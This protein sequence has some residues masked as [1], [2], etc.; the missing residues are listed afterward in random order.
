MDP[1]DDG[2]EQ[3]LRRVLTAQ[4]WALAPTP[5][6]VDDV[7]AGVRRRRRNRAVALSTAGVIVIAGGVAAGVSLISGN[8]GRDTIKTPATQPPA[9][10]HHGPFVPWRATPGRLTVN[11]DTAQSDAYT[12]RTTETTAPACTM[13]DLGTALPPDG[14]AGSVYGTLYVRNTSVTPCSVQGVPDV[15]LLDAHGQVV[16]STATA[17]TQQQQAP[18]VVLD[19]GS[20][21]QAVIGKLAND[22]CGGQAS[23]QVRVSVS[24]EVGSTTFAEAFGGPVT[25]NCGNYTDPGNTPGNLHPQ[26]FTAIPGHQVTDNNIHLS[27]QSPQQVSPNTEV[28]YYVTVGGPPGSRPFAGPCPIFAQ[29]I[30]DST[31]T[32]RLNCKAADRTKSEQTFEIHMRVPND[33]S[34]IGHAMTTIDWALLTPVWSGVEGG[35]AYVR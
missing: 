12:Q 17:T 1:L 22:T 26:A 2:L 31:T 21:A 4:R 28:S 30:G 15:E 11:P 6:A 3:D 18:A 24:H 7:H 23:T 16:Q 32:Y 20:W 5:G 19:P 27:V 10:H 34:I 8:G 14:A 35:T 33:S 25:Q 9:H 13:T 29:T